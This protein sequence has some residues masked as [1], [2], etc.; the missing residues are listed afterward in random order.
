L[1]FPHARRAIKITRWRQDTSAGRASRQA[2]YAVTSLTSAHATAADLARLVREQWSIEMV[3]TQLAKRAVRPFG[4][5]WEHVAD[6]GQVGV[7]QP[8]LLAVQL[9]QGLADRR[10]PGVEFLGQ[11]GAALRPV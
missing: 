6:L 4:G 2:V 11:P 5:G 7:E 8:L 10:L 3:F 9:A 1:D